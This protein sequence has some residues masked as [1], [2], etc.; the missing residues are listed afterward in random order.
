MLVFEFIYVILN[1]T[2]STM[3]IQNN[4]REWL[5]VKLLCTHAKSA[6]NCVVLS[7]YCNLIKGWHIIK[8]T[9]VASSLDEHVRYPAVSMTVISKY[10]VNIAENRQFTFNLQ[11]K[12]QMTDT[13]LDFEQTGRCLGY[14]FIF[15]MLGTHVYIQAYIQFSGERFKNFDSHVYMNISPKTI[16][17]VKT[18]LEWIKH[19]IWCEFL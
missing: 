18:L 3:T 14:Y 13:A 19:H 12:H 9:S 17:T 11:I 1:A 16:K 15:F 5:F 2:G 10:I 6:S 8:L 4:L 7:L